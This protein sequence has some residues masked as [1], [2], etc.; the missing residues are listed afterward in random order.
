MN[1]K[2]ILM[3][4][5]VISFLLITSIFSILPVKA[6][7]LTGQLDV[8]KKVRNGGSWANSIDADIGETVQFKLKLKYYNL[9]AGEHYAF[10]ISVVD[11][12]PPSLEYDSG[13]ASPFEP[14]V[15]GNILTWDLDTVVLYHNDV[16]VITFNAT[17]I[18]C[19]ENINMVEASADEYCTGQVLVGEDTATVNV[20]CPQPGI[21]VEKTVWDGICQW[22]KEIWANNNS[23]VRFNITVKNTGGTELENVTVVDTLSDSL[24]YADNATLAPVISG[25]GKILTWNIGNLSVGQI[26]YI[27]FDATVTGKPCD[28]DENLVEATADEKCG[29]DIYDSD[30]AIVHIN[31]M[32]LEKLVWDPVEKKWS[33]TATVEQGDNVYFRIELAYHGNYK[34]YNIKVKDVLPPCLGNGETLW[35]NLTVELY[36]GDSYTIEFNVTAANNNCQPCINW[37]YITAN[38]C[39][40]K[41]FHASDSATVYIECAFTADAGG[42]YTGE[43]DESVAITGSATGGTAPYTYAW[44]MDNDGSYDD[45]T[46]KTI[47]WSWDEEGVYVIKLKVTDSTGKKAYD[48]TSVTIVGGNNPPNKP[49]RPSGYSLIRLGEKATYFASTTDPDGDD[50]YYLFDWGDGT[51][52]GWVGPFPS[53]TLGDANHTW[54]A[55][56]KHMIKVKAKDTHGAE[57]DWSDPLPIS[58]PRSR[59][60]LNNPILLRILEYLIEKFPIFEKLF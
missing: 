59:T 17:V 54:T 40:G 57:T 60:I 24:A 22:K 16:Y 19:G 36:N 49:D 11:T 1:K 58:V 4:T 47:S 31:G 5:L 20:E 38:E 28:T 21:D 2:I 37:V 34:L 26:F 35:W 44:D 33:K 32:C 45:A 18:D 51:D 50:I 23:N 48:D 9:T 3:G 30:T 13:S 53:G 46:G 55:S 12:L 10:N 25:G 41:I 52:S 43:V 27:E 39:S 8:I 14:D 7:N 42:P 15:A 6:V 56:G 29:Q